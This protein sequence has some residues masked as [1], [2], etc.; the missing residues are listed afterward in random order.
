MHRRTLLAAAVL[1]P[2]L[3]SAHAQGPAPFQRTAQDQADIA[4][5]ETY[6]DGIRTLKARFLQVAPNGAI[7]QGTAWL[8]R[9]GRLRF[10]YDPPAPYLLVANY[11]Q[12]VFFD[13]QLNQTTN[14]FLS[15]TPLGIL[16]AEHVRLSGDVTV[17]G[18]SR[19]SGQLQVTLVRTSSP[20]DGS[21][22]LVFSDP[23]LVLRQWIT[24]DAQRKETRVTLYDVQLGGTFNQA[25]FNIATPVHRPG[26]SNG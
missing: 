13:T 3:R 5:I 17:T 6:L 2:V 16:L 24:I 1:S 21:L 14:L 8:D 22:T 7:T 9:P 25:L 12:L 4:R 18:V 19:L 20:S 23:P 10:Q 26:S 11:G 15:R